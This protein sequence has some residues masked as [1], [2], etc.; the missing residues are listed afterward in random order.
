MKTWPILIIESESEV[1]FI[2]LYKQRFYKVS[3]LDFHCAIFTILCSFRNFTTGSTTAPNCSHSF[4]SR[5]ASRSIAMS[6]VYAVIVFNQYRIN[7]TNKL[8]HSA[9]L[10]IS[11]N[12]LITI[13][14]AILDFPL[15]WSLACFLNAV[16]V[17]WHPV[18]AVPH[19]Q[20]VSSS[21]C[22]PLG[23]PTNRY[24]TGPRP[25]LFTASCVPSRV[26]RTQ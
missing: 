25:S 6:I 14:I 26:T 3:I 23:R 2:Y 10:F 9:I 16:V 18:T 17:C 22:G 4:M 11:S 20:H 19:N 24:A 8:D 12:V 5:I 7:Y 13:L 15:F 21:C 1:A